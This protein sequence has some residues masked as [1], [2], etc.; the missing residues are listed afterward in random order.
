MTINAVTTFGLT[1]E[2]RNDTDWFF[3]Y[4]GKIKVCD[5]KNLQVKLP[6]KLITSV[7]GL[8]T[9]TN[10]EGLMITEKIVV[11][12]PQGLE[13]FFPNLKVLRVKNRR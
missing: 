7:N 1:C 8:A 12:L 9:P 6:D 5:A 13:E 2:V 4:A 11:C 10:I 3:I